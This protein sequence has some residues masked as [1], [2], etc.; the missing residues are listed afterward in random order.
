MADQYANDQVPIGGPA[1]H[2]A[3]ITPDDSNDLANYSRAIYVGGAGAMKVTTVGGET[4]LIS[5]LLAGHVYPL[6]VKRIWSTTT[7]ATLIQAW[8]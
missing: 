3:L 8:W 2:A 4:L 7:T 6:R 5:G 1:Q